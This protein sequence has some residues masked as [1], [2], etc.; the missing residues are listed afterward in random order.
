MDAN[1]RKELETLDDILSLNYPIHMFGQEWH[2]VSNAN[3]AFDAQY[4]HILQYLT[5]NCIVPDT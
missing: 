1:L 4:I 2:T 5:Q 3:R